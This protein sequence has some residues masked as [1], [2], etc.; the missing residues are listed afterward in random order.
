MQ[1]LPLARFILNI[2]SARAGAGPRRDLPGGLFVCP[3]PGPPP[4]SCVGTRLRPCSQTSVKVSP[5]PLSALS[6]LRLFP[7]YQWAHRDTG[8]QEDGHC[9]KS[10]STITVHGSSRNMAPDAHPTPASTFLLL[11]GLQ[12]GGGGACFTHHVSPALGLGPTAWPVLSLCPANLLLNINPL[13]RL[14]RTVFKCE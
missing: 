13:A 8:C 11:L 14:A 6:T 3:S 9:P 12:G 2:Y 1:S 4:S 10:P 5:L 7:Q